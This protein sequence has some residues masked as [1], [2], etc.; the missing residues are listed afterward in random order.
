M[1]DTDFPEY[2]RQCELKEPWRDYHRGTIVG[3]NGYR[4]IIELSS[5]ARIELYDEIEFD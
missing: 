3:R 1:D 2:G 4:Y 5:G